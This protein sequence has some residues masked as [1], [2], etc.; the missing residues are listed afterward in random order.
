MLG[1]RILGSGELHLTGSSLPNLLIFAFKLSSLLKINAKVSASFGTLKF[2]L[3]LYLLPG[4]YF[5]IGF[6]LRR[7]YLGDK[8][9]LTMTCVPS[10]KANLNLPLICFSLV[11]K[12]C[13]C[14]G[15]STPGL[16]RKKF[17]IVGQWI[18]SSSTPP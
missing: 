12:L 18:I 8:L 6:P 17:F 14:G 15:N 1:F 11:K 2:L 16:G 13:L 5:G 10:V 9:R 3:E 7:T 4:D